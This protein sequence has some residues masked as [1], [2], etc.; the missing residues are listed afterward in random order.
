MSHACSNCANEGD[1]WDCTECDGCGTLTGEA[2]FVDCPTAP[3]YEEPGHPRM[4]PIAMPTD[5]GSVEEGYVILRFGPPRPIEELFTVVGT[6]WVP[7]TPADIDRIEQAMEDTDRTGG[8]EALD[9]CRVEP[10]GECPHGSPSILIAR[11]I[12]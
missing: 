12:L 9:G 1:S 7:H 11:G 5:D 8:C 4:E 3:S 10:D 6:G 2:H